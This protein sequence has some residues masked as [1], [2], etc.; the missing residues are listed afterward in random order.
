MYLV[1]A[2]F[3]RTLFGTLPGKKKKSLVSH[4]FETLAFISFEKHKY[5]TTW[6][7]KTEIFVCP[8]TTSHEV[9]KRGPEI[10]I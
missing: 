6:G 1:K 3:Y 4:T 8:W 10:K 9:R 2:S 5:L 7:T